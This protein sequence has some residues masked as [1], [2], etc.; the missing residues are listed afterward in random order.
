M[1]EWR[2]KTKEN[3]A[4]MMSFNRRRHKERK[5]KEEKR[6]EERRFIEST[7]LFSARKRKEEGKSD[8]LKSF[9]LFISLLKR[10][11]T[12]FFTKTDWLSLSTAAEP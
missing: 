8:R 4:A 11:S 1:K 10:E 2:E 6:G 9:F 7:F 5:R 3:R 12:A